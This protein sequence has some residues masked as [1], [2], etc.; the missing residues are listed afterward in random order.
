MGKTAS[1]SFLGGLSDPLVRTKVVQSAKIFF[2]NFQV[3]TSF[4]SFKVNLPALLLATIRYLYSIGILL[5]FD[6]FSWPGMGCM[7]QVDTE[8][9][10][11]ARTLFPLGIF[12]FINVTGAFLLAP[13]PKTFERMR[14]HF[15]EEVDEKSER[16]E[17]SVLEQRTYL[18]NAILFTIIVPP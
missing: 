6:L 15:E 8:T 16:Y 11:Y 9:R 18:V 13:S 2:G 7:V 5:S 10:I 3:L 17:R 4:F 1:K 14:C 12:F